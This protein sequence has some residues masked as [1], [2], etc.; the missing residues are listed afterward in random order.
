M[1]SKIGT[2]SGLAIPSK[3]NPIIPSNNA[4]YK[5]PES[6]I[7][8]LIVYSFISSPFK[9]TVSLPSTPSS[10]PFPALWGSE[11][12]AVRSAKRVV[13]CPPSRG[14]SWKKERTRRDANKHANFN[15]FAFHRGIV[16]MK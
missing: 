10:V 13:S 4:S 14:R 7:I 9:N 6:D 11:R 12:G 15:C 5:V 2:S 8:R 3:A 16:G 1:L